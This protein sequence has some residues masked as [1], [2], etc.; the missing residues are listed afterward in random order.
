M[1]SVLV[2]GGTGFIGAR[3]VAALLGQGITPR[4]FDLAPRP[5]RL[6]SGDAAR[7]EVVVGDVVDADALMLAAQGCD[8]IIHLAGLMTV[9]CARQPA[10]AIR[11]NIEGSLN[12]FEVARALGL[13]VSYL[14]SSAVFG[15]QDAVT[16]EPMTLYG[17]TK[18]AVEGV[19]RVYSAEYGVPSLG[20]RPYVVYGP[21]ESSGIAAG[22]SIA[23]AASLR[24]EP[25][26]IGF[27]GRV[28]FVHA[29]DVAR[30]LVAGITSPAAAATVLTL[31]GETRSMDDFVTE[32]SSQSGWSGVSI[33]GPPL[34]IPG[35]IAS[36]PVPAWL[37]EH[38][39]TS[40]RAGIAVTIQELRAAPPPDGGAVSA[41][42]I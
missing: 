18:L 11:I 41:P 12:I 32:L 20:L 35:D 30:L 31:A 37:G 6:R 13:P 19:A 10:L 7:C 16:P 22:P 38:P 28:G 1:S 27:S 2:V 36:D 33:K 42:T 14:S 24:C 17:V 15:P 25:A 21:G 23:I 9:D 26:T 39:V 5:D 4:L 29:D 34:K 40:I 3:V 8:G